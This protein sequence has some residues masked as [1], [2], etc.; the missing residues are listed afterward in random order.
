MTTSEKMPP[1]MSVIGIEHQ[2]RNVIMDGG[3]EVN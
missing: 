2:A 1:P 3:E